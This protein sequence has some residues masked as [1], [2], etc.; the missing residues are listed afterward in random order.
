MAPSVTGQVIAASLAD[1]DSKGND[2]WCGYS[3]SWMS[4]LRAPRRRPPK[5]PSRMLDIYAN[6]FVLRKRLPC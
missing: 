2:A 1:W 3:F 4:C 6:A 5:W